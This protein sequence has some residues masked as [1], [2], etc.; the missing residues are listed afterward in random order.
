MQTSAAGRLVSETLAPE[1][2]SVGRARRLVRAALAA[3]GYDEDL[4]DVVTLLVSEVVTNSL[5]HAGT[6][7][8]LR[9]ERRG[10][11]V[12]VEVF[13]RSALVPTV[14][15][16][17]SE[18]TTGRGLA[19]VSTPAVSW[20]VRLHDHGK[21]LWFDVGDVGAHA[22]PGTEP[23][24]GPV[25]STELA[26][27]VR[28]PGASPS[29]IRA[30]IEQGDA[31]LRE[32][33]LLTLGGELDDAVPSGWQ[34]SQID[35]G[36]ILAAVEAAIGAGEPKTDLEVTMPAG[37]GPAGMER[38]RLIDVADALARGD[39]LLSAPALPE[40]AACRHWLYT[41]IAEQERG[42]PAQHWEL[43]EPLEPAQVAAA[44]PPN[45][46]LRLRQLSVP[47]VVADDANCIIFVNVAA[48]EL[49]GWAPEALVGQR[50][51]VLIPPQLRE[52]HLA[53]FS[54]LQVTGEA[55][56]LGSAVHVPA[57]RRD[58]SLVD[59][60]LTINVVAGGA[61]RTAFC[62]V[63]G[64][65]PNEDPLVSDALSAVA[66]PLCRSRA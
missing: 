38:L 30:A 4:A 43:P 46:L 36:P 39:R 53:G 54:R 2:A 40:I 25:Q 34:Q 6:E 9:C 16:Y 42:F 60:S 19:L 1:P 28:L 13:D 50:L 44:L 64:T 65:D 17:D 49:F 32:L 45:E 27:V 56:I 3:A 21:T 66:L 55:R 24:P 61:G 23:T 52:A 62:A 63:L 7:M 18:A 33:A 48:G 8:G 14:R 11:G 26:F 35:V 15:H 37:A 47:A 59:V 12:R 51:T 20:G 10:A 31:L 29:L 22:A 57:L 5:L 41:Q 58:G